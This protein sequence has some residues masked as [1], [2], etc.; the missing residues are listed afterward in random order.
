MEEALH[1]FTKLKNKEEL[2]PDEEKR[3]KEW[4]AKGVMSLK[5]FSPNGKEKAKVRQV[6]DQISDKGITKAYEE[7][8]NQAKKGNQKGSLNRALLTTM[9]NSEKQK[10]AL[11]GKARER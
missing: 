7:K 8:L 4:N 10:A 9:E 2:T 1:L 6:V 5:D 11:K 3:V